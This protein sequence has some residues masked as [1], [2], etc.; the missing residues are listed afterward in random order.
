MSEIRPPAEEE[1]LK[2]AERPQ[3]KKRVEETKKGEHIQRVVR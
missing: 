1:K 3:F 2:E